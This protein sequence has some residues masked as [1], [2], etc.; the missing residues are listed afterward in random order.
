MAYHSKPLIVHSMAANGISAQPYSSPLTPYMWT[1]PYLSPLTPYMWAHRDC[2][3]EL[4]SGTV[5]GELLQVLIPVHTPSGIR[6]PTPGQRG[7]V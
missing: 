3:T 7:H 1:Q 4:H 5:L 2:A 6:T